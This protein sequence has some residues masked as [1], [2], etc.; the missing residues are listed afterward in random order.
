MRIG[1]R[2]LFILLLLLCGVSASAQVTYW[3]D[4]SDANDYAEFTRREYRIATKMDG[5]KAAAQFADLQRNT[6][7]ILPTPETGQTASTFWNLDAPEWWTRVS[8][9]VPGSSTSGQASQ[10]RSL[11]KLW[12]GLDSYQRIRATLRASAL[13]FQCLK[14]L[15]FEVNAWSMMQNLLVMQEGY[16]IQQD[17]TQFAQVP[18]GAVTISVVPQGKDTWRDIVKVFKDSPW[19]DSNHQVRW[20]GPR[21]LSGISIDANEVG[22]D[23]TLSDSDATIDLLQR[24]D[25]GARTAAEGIASIRM[26]VAQARR[27]ALNDAFSP[28][29][30]ASQVR[31]LN[32]RILASYGS[33]L[34]LRALLE[35]RD[36]QEL[37]NE[38]NNLVIFSDTQARAAKTQAEMSAKFYQ[39]LQNQASNVTAELELPTRLTAIA[40][41]EKEYE[42]LFNL[43][44]N[45]S[46][47]IQDIDGI[48]ASLNTVLTQLYPAMVPYIGG[49]ALPVEVAGIIS[50]S[51][52]MADTD[53][54]NPDSDLQGMFRDARVRALAVRL[55]YVLWEELRASR[56]LAT[57]QEEVAAA[58]TGLETEQRSWQGLKNTA[59]NQLDRQA[60]LYRLG[61]TRAAIDNWATKP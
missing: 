29:R 10:N 26:G 40:S 56:R 1:S 11:S 4:P 59:N 24:M 19:D 15:R 45:G 21:S 53:A 55:N 3:L 5:P 18:Q 31:I 36:P 7:S 35:G 41:I 32:Q 44:S 22:G 9:G 54:Q 37:Q 16:A 57:I 17:G 42:A 28:R 2:W 33:M 13:M 39:D 49:A 50:G 8:S 60:Q 61:V 12:E 43:S 23:P 20:I 25:V 6:L 48:M 14:G 46:G 47:I 30:L 34:Q 38:Y 27:D 58:N 52:N 51:A